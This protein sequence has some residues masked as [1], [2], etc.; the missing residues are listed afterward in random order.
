MI[1]LTI[2]LVPI[3]NLQVLFKFGYL[4]YLVCIMVLMT[5]EGVN[6]ITFVNSL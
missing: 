6:V 1:F 4:P 5:K 2:C 3:K